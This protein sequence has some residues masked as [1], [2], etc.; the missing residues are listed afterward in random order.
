MFK[1]EIIMLEIYYDGNVKK[2]DTDRQFVANQIL[3]VPD[4]ED[5]VQVQKATLN[6]KELD[7]EPKTM[8]G[9]FNYLNK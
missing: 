4:F 6:G 9:L 1:G 3:E 5:Y 7:F 8:I 2:Y